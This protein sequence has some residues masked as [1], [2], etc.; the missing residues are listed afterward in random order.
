VLRRPAYLSAPVIPVDRLGRASAV[1]DDI[2]RC[3][4]CPAEVALGM[5]ASWVFW[6]LVIGVDGG[7]QTGDD[8]VFVIEGLGHGGQAIGGTGGA[9]DDRFAAVQDVMV[10]IENDGLQVAGGGG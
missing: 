3:G 10:H 2:G 5:G 8:A 7:H 4:P 9:A 6:S 1:G